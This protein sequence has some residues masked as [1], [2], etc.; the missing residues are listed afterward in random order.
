ME[1]VSTVIERLKAHVP[2]IHATESLPI[3]QAVGRVLREP[4]TAP[5][6]V[7]FAP[8]SLFDGYAVKGPF[9][10]GER[11]AVVGKQFAG[12]PPSGLE[13][14]AAMR[15]FTGA[16]LPE[17]ADTVIAQESAPVQSDGTIRC[18]EALHPGLACV[19]PGRTP[20]RVKCC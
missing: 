6:D 15:I 3:R 17:G 18:E 9:A 10:E 14:G 20:A 4:L 13:V 2:A 7:P 19:P 12:D 16:L 5:R 1:A 11:L 8:L